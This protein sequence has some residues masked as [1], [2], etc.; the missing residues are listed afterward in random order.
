[1]N[2]PVSPADQRADRIF[3]LI[4][5]HQTAWDLYVAVDF[6][7]GHQDPALHARAWRMTDAA[8]AKIL[9]TPPTSRAGAQAVTKHL[10]EVFDESRI[11]PARR[12]S[13]TART[14]KYIAAVYLDGERR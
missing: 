14:A 3:A 8:H 11:P 13:I 2:A 5:V 7:L 9:E 10:L 6:F 1:V 4:R 12:R